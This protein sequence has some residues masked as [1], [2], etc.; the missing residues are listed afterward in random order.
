MDDPLS[1]IANILEIVG[2][3]LTIV[4]LLFG[5]RIQDRIKELYAANVALPYARKRLSD[6]LH[7]LEGHA[8]NY[9][10]ATL[11]IDRAMRQMLGNLIQTSQILQPQDRGTVDGLASDIQGYLKTPRGKTVDACWAIIGKGWQVVEELTFLTEKG[12]WQI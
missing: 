6:L 5:K 9:A 8:P 3:L 4:L 1:L 7:E 12:R 10:G 11:L 2:F